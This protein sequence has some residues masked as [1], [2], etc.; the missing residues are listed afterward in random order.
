MTTI[1]SD[2]EVA[3]Q[4]LRVFIENGVSAGDTLRRNHFASVRDAYFQRGMNK[5]VECGWIRL[6]RDRYTYELTK[7]GFSNP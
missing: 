7:T 2:E 3:H 4:I 5:A 1:P 6:R